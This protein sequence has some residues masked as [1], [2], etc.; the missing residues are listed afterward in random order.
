MSSPELLPL[1]ALQTVRSF[2]PFLVLVWMA[3]GVMGVDTNPPVR[4]DDGLSE[5][6]RP[7]P[8]ER[9]WYYFQTCSARGDP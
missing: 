1:P 6:G 3:E 7:F 8:L 9:K 2:G 5:E 4:F